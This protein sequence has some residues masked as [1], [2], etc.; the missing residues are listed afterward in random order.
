MLYQVSDIAYGQCIHTQ[1]IY[2]TEAYSTHPKTETT[3]QHFAVE[4][5]KCSVLNVYRMK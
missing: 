5:C 1:Y 3:Y 4:H 2:T